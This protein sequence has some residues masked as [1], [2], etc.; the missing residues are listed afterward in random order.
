MSA[1]LAL[2]SSLFWG[3]ADFLAGNLTK[4]YA[5]IAV[6]GVSQFFGLLVGLAIMLATNAYI[7]PTLH[8]SSYLLPGI[9]A[10]I[11]G[12]LGLISYYSGLATGQMGVVAPIS[13]L[14]AV[15][16]LIYALVRGEHLKSIQIAG[17]LVAL[18]G[19]FCASGPH[20]AGRLPLKP[21]F[22]GAGAALGFGSAL[23][24]MA[25]GSKSSA[26]MTMTTM[27]VTTFIFCLVIAAR[28]KNMGG[29]AA[30]DFRILAVIGVIDFLA[31][32]L[33][34][35]ATTKGLVSIAMILG[36][37]FPIVTVLLAYKF[38]HER[39][40]KVQYLGVGFAILGVGL[41]SL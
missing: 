26:I 19:G 39:L 35:V 13:S 23:A 15:I 9:F 16:P 28:F 32:F 2:L 12:F 40:H 31:N 20:I 4:R 22:F 30:K 10:G 18:L 29:F 3:T 1:A 36:S 5:A 33:L 17:I 34:G 41:I 6:T 21:L 37:L 38:L 8:W 11:C 7:A 25:Q 24:F 27:R 14:S